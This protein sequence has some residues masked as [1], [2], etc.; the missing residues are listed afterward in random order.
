M[1]PNDRLLAEGYGV[2]LTQSPDGTTTLRRRATFKEHL[3][4]FATP[5]I[6]GLCVVAAFATEHASVGVMIVAGTLVAS[7]FALRIL[8]A[9]RGVR[10]TWTPAGAFRVH[11]IKLLFTA[12][13]DIGLDAL[14]PRHEDGTLVSVSPYTSS[15]PGGRTTTGQ[16]ASL[17]L[18]FWTASPP[19]LRVTF[20]TRAHHLDH[21]VSAV[22]AT[23]PKATRHV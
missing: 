17:T 14:R 15:A 3:W 22:E 8:N 20:P 12:P 7:A 10:V 19:A 21:L 1:D 2:A 11:T 4:G 9:A 5:L 23:L 16:Y 13:I 6:G 18:I